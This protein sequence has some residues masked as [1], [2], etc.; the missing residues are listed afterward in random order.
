MRQVLLGV[1]FQILSE[2]TLSLE[3]GPFGMIQSL[4]NRMTHFQNV[5]YRFIRIAGARSVPTRNWCRSPR[6]A[7]D[8]ATTLLLLLPCGGLGIAL[9]LVACA[10]GR[11]GVWRCVARKR[12][13]EAGATGGDRC[14]EGLPHPPP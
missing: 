4:L 14:A 8:V 5:L 7:I 9:E 6:G 2:W 1:G 10:L 11:G 12:V 13:D 3:Q